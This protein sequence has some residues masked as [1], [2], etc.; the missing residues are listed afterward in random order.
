MMHIKCLFSSVKIY[1]FAQK[2]S[3]DN[4]LNFYNIDIYSVCTTYW[5]SY[6]LDTENGLL[7]FFPN[8]YF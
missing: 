2:I 5:I 3:E 7:S 4:L 6:I 1:S 8:G